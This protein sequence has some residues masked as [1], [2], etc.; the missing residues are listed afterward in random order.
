M[1]LIKTYN[2]NDEKKKSI[3]LKIRICSEGFFCIIS[4]AEHFLFDQKKKLMKTRKRDFF[5]CMNLHSGSI[6]KS[7]CYL[8]FAVEITEFLGTLL[9][10]NSEHLIF[11]TDLK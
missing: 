8:W 4:I 9:V 1:K 7:V 10:S 3:S 6:Q 2:T 5:L 11:K